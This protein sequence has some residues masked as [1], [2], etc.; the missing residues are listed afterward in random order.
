MRVDITGRHIEITP[1]LRQLIDKSL[2]RVE[3]LLN[4]RAISATVVLTKE[5]Y[6]HQTELVVHAKG[7]HILSG[8]GEGNTWPLSLRKAAAKIEHQAQTLKS[9]WTEGKRQ[10][11]NNRAVAAAL[12]PEQPV[13]SCGPRAMPSSRCRLTTPRCG[14]SRYRRPSS[15]SGTRTPM[16]SASCSAARTATWDSS[17]LTDRDHPPPVASRQLSMDMTSGVPVAVLLRDLAE[18]RGI[19]LELLAGAA[20]IDRRIT[21][22][23]PQKTGLALT[24][25]DKYLREGRVLVLGESEV[26][27]L[28]ALAPDE[29]TA[30]M[31]Q[32]F[33]HAL[34]CIVVTAGL[35]PPPEVLA[36]AD[37][38]RLPVLKTR[39]ATPLAMDRLSD[40]L[41]VY[42]AARA[43][44][45]GVL[46]DILGLGVLIVGES[47][48]GK[49]ECALDLVV[50]GHRLVADDA[51]EL[52]ARGDTY[53]MGT[54][55]EL[56]RH[57]MEIRGLGLI[58]VQDLFGVAST[59]GSKRVELVVQLERWDPRRE[60]DRLGLDEA[61][62]ETVGVRVPMLRMPVAPGRNLAILVEVAARNQLLRNGGLNAARRLVDRLDA[63]LGDAREGPD[64]ESGDDL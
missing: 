17:N 40:A 34:P 8:I 35:C 23:H 51:V 24:G 2:A 18:P 6:R 5:K 10:R 41:D 42:L 62:Y 49:S 39:A 45:H 33:T 57:H 43:V 13:V 3:R 31:R 4:A 21:N 25:F 60:Y 32:V 44:V 52:R 16:P 46:M 48:I 9:R 47:G 61:H 29:R 59:R 26:R 20:G 28:E 63:Q 19:D 53:L 1:G 11:Q 56:T 38:A 30:V 54:C 14:S 64:L 15:C 7:D 12:A 36:E 50:R 27:V 37:R 58:N 55:P 22:P